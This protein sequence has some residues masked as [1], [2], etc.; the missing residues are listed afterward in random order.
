MIWTTKKRSRRNAGN[1]ASG[2]RSASAAVTVMEVSMKPFISL[3]TAERVADT[4]MNV[5]ERAA[6]LLVWFAVP[7]AV[8]VIVVAVLKAWGE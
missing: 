3:E 4:V 6:N 7:A 5:L 2:G 8:Y 1:A